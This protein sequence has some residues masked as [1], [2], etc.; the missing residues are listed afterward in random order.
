MW[1]HFR[2]AA[3][4]RGEIGDL[5]A[6]LHCPHLLVQ[7]I[8]C[9]SLCF[10]FDLKLLQPG[11]RLSQRRRVHLEEDSFQKGETDIIQ[12]VE[13]RSRKGGMHTV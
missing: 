5:P 1:V 3:L 13:G 12:G 9:E 2:R 4:L 8:H 10:L 11:R 7:V 6:P